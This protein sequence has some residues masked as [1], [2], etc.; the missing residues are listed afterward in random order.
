MEKIGFAL[1]VEDLSKSYSTGWRKPLK[2]ALD[3]LSFSLPQGR[4]MGLLGPNGAGKTTTLKIIMDFLRPDRGR[5]LIMGKDW[6]DPGNRCLLGFLPEQPYYHLYQTPRKTLSFFGKLLGMDDRQIE[7][8][9]S[10]LLELVGLGELKDLSLHR[11]SKGML[12]RLGIAQA[13]LNQPELLILDEPSSGLDPVGKAEMRTLLQEI[14][15][16]GT[17][18]LLSSHQ[19][20]E[21]EEICDH[22]C[23]IDKGRQVAQG[24]LEELL[25]EGDEY[26]IVLEKNPALDEA[27]MRMHGA[28]LEDESRLIFPRSRLDSMLREL[29]GGGA[30]ILEAKPR[31]ITLE[32]FFLSR[33]GSGREG[34]GK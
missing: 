30:K 19:L 3:G 1:E 34:E 11:F 27:T 7:L 24:S 4:I 23:I 12:Q 20:S 32:E 14:Q 15:A 6:R 28:R 17:A 13:L 22:L 25:G 29:I 9:I 16:Q 21:V 5:V 18:I 8:R 33:V 26:E 2:L 31:R 10:F